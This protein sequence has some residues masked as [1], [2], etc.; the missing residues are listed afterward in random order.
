MPGEAPRPQLSG[1]AT[2]YTKMSGSCAELHGSSMAQ[3]RR[4]LCVQERHQ[5]SEES[6]AAGP[7]EALQR[8]TWDKAAVTYMSS[9]RRLNRMMYTPVDA[10]W[11]DG[12]W[13]RDIPPRRCLGPNPLALRMRPG[14]KES[15]MENGMVYLQADGELRI[16]TEL[17]RVKLTW[18]H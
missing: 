1:R 2:W 12:I 11:T 4:A 5:C 8:E 10:S 13:G 15:V 7:K 18:W 9:D 14:A 6:T 17:K 3:G 16:E